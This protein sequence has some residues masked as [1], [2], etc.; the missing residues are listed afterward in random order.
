LLKTTRRDCIV[1]EYRSTVATFTP[2]SHTS[3]LPRLALFVEIHA[4]SPPVKVNF[5][6]ALEALA[7]FT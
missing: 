3:A 1:A 2:S 5:A 4:T 7:R 6:L